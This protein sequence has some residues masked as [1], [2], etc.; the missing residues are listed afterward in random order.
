MNYV[1]SFNLLGVEA[2]QRPTIIG[3]GKPIAVVAAIG[4]LY[5]DTDTDMLYVCN[6]VDE[7]GVC[8]WLVVNQSML[9]E[10]F[11]DI[12]VTAELNDK[13]FSTTTI[14][15]TSMVHIANYETKY[16]I[17]ISL[18][19]DNVTDFSGVNVEKRG[20]N[21]IDVSK[22]I[23]G[24]NI[25]GLSYDKAT[26]TVSLTKT[27][28]DA[29]NAYAYV[30]VF[31]P[32]GVYTLSV[33]E[34]TKAAYYKDGVLIEPSENEPG[35][36]GSVGIYNDS[37]LI[38]DL[39]MPYTANGYQIE[40]T[41][42]KIYKIRFAAYWHHPENTTL[43]FKG[44]QL[45]LNST[46]TAFEP[47][48]SQKGTV[49]A[50]GTV[51]GLDFNGSNMF[52]VA[53]NA[54]VEV[55]AT[56]LAIKNSLSHWTNKKWAAIGDSITIRT[57]NYVDTVA[58]A[59]S[60]T[61]SNLGISGANSIIMRESFTD[62]TSENYTPEKEQAVKDAD[63]ITI[64]GC[65]NDWGANGGLPLGDVNNIQSGTFLNNFNKLLQAVVDKNPNADV[66][67]IGSHNAWDSYR[68]GDNEPVDG[69]D[70][71]R[72]YVNAMGELAKIYGFE[73][74]NMY[75]LTDFHDVKEQKDENG[76]HIYLPDGVHPSEEGYK[77]ISSILINEL[78][79]IGINKQ[80]SSGIYGYAN[81]IDGFE[82]S[83]VK[84]RQTPTLVGVGEPTS[85]IPARAGEL[86]LDVTKE[87]VYICTHSDTESGVRSWSWICKDVDTKINSLEETII[88]VDEKIDSAAGLTSNAKQILIEILKNG[89]YSTDQRENIAALTFELGVSEWE[90]VR[91][92]D[93]DDIVYGMSAFDGARADRAGYYCYD[94]PIEYGYTY[95][96]DVI[97]TKSTTQI[98]LQF[99]DQAN[100][101]RYLTDGVHSYT[102]YDSGWKTS[103]VEIDIPNDEIPSHKDP[104]VAVNLT[105]RMDDTNSNVEEGFITG[106]T[107]SRKPL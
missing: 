99:H 9:D 85:S 33:K 38:S 101:D 98:G 26:G 58:S 14:S 57:G 8:S 55:T 2:R 94:I 7:D 67:I 73:F 51:S 6:E 41:E 62:S 45:E 48:N 82:V 68:P 105:F 93:S 22:V 81:Y 74:I 56:Y 53:D 29:T 91:T 13:V 89:V 83:G 17:D 107:I 88:E 90:V 70:T 54:S 104:I 97:S 52:I 36:A 39:K 72:D 46:A 18:S 100:V 11:D 10:K 61:A 50:D 25:N 20:K 79:K 59:L 43:S 64:Y 21:L 4:D 3:Q 32:A 84:V 69:T 27:S 24:S 106:V 44:V 31:T 65:V 1:E 30:D 60:M 63:L 5:L 34:G 49:N 12:G 37:T 23:A 96:F 86:Y 66:V 87:R 77:V 80:N 75:E 92:L 71:I 42:S 102:I 40:I 15:G 78:K 76:N 95:K 35:Q 47:Y 103:G 28:G 19:S 16:P